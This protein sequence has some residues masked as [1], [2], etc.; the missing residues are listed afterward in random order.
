MITRRCSERRFLLRP[1]HETNNAFIYC[2]A[3]AAERFGIQVIF[4]YA[5]AN[6]HHTGIFDPDGLFPDFMAYFHKYVAKCQNALRGRFENFWSSE[7]ASV[8][9]LVEPDD[10]LEKMIY[11]LTNPVKDPLVEHVWEWPGVN[12]YGATVDGTIL[13][14]AR[15]AHFFRKDG[16]MPEMVT[17][18]IARPQGFEKMSDE[19]F[20]AL[21]KA[22]VTAAEESAAADRR[23]KGI[24]VLGRERILNQ[25][26]R[27]R[28]KSAEPRFNL[29]PRVA[30]MNKWARIEALARNTHFIAAYIAAKDDFAK[31]LRDVVFPPGTWWLRKHVNVRCAETARAPA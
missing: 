11:A 30:A 5:A 6:H 27:A 14:A 26:W 8:V 2:L 25:D 19:D 31:G 9:R 29:S 13:S 1:D 22:R 4:T 24:N 28:P 18:P 16:T 3:V 10:I 15:P 23:A 7:H 21:I 20:A 12:S 17:L